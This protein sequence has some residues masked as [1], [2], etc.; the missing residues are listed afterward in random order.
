[1][2][3]RRSS[4]AI[5]LG[6]RI[7]ALRGRLELTQE[8]LAWPADLASKGYLSR[9]E[10]GQRLPSLDVLERLARCLRVEPRDLL[11]FPDTSRLAEAMELTRLGGE[12]AAS[13]V[14]DLL[15]RAPQ[16]RPEVRGLRAAEPRPPRSGR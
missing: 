9:I 12:L 2:A 7:V 14:I 10:S 8:Q 15:G 11:L 1:M 6:R 4:L 5:R 13:R 3:V 16:E